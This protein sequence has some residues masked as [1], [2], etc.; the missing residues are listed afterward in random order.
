MTKE[1]ISLS[2]TLDLRAILTRMEKMEAVCD[3]IIEIMDTYASQE[4]AGY[5]D[6]P[7]GLEH[8]GDVWRKFKA[9]TEKLK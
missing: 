5:V 1:R 8:M 6:T 3:E 4:A 9:W 2:D 7:G